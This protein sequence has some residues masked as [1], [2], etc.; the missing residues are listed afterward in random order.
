MAVLVLVFGTATG[1]SGADE[2]TS[3]AVF[4]DTTVHEIR[5]AM[6]S[7]D[8]SQLQAHYLE[9]TF[10]PADVTWN[11]YT[12]RNA[13]VRSRGSGSR[14]ARKPGLRITFDEY[15]DDQTFAGLKGLV[16]DNFRQDPGMMKEALS[17][18]LFA[19][20]GL[21]APRVSHAR[22][23][24]NDD[25]LG[26][27]AVIEPI[28]KRF[29]RRTLGEDG[30][31]LY[32]FE[33]AGAYH[34]EWLGDDPLRYAE[35]FDSETRENE[36]PAQRFS[37]LVQMITATTRESTSSW[38][39]TMGRYFDFERLFAYLAVE[40]FLSDHDGLTGDWGIN[41]FYLYRFAA[42]DRF[43][44]LPWDKDVNFREIDRDVN[45]SLDANFLF[46]TAMEFR[47]LRDA[48][49]QALRKCAA[50]ATQADASGQGWL[51]R[52]VGRHANQIR[53]AAH[54]DEKKA[55]SNE[56]FEQEVAWMSSFARQRSG[57][58]ER[59]VGR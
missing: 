43:Q 14:D 17:M 11:G 39:R 13:G 52:E 38:E 51:E 25:Y 49:I 56:R 37:T 53:G 2:P 26:L 7:G 28:D 45:E 6:H 58:V 29:L 35:M 46:A 20:M 40:N 1:A 5:L 33:W 41:N 50:I 4:D 42:S 30:G 59:Q 23:Y 36:T 16:L 57:Q 44:F 48:Y 9:N 3:A 18:A 12:V 22:V 32:E 10:Y 31:Y 55:W 47:D 21:A 19:R 15:V 24:V 34:F 8:W 27:F 54:T